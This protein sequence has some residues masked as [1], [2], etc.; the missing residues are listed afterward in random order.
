MSKIV[1]PDEFEILLDAVVV[2]DNMTN[3]I[4]D[5]ELEGANV[6]VSSVDLYNMLQLLIDLA[7]H[8][9]GIDLE[10]LVGKL[11]AVGH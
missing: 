2:M 1:G 8:H 6:L 10:T 9:E 4:D 5:D 3:T 11:Y 7:A